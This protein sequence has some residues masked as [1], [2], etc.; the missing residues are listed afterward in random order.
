MS[1]IIVALEGAP[2]LC[3]NEINKEAKLNL[4]IES[5]IKGIFNCL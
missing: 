2:K 1:V 3:P 5:S 4:D